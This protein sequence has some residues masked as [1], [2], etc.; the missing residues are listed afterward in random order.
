[1][2]RVLSEDG[3]SIYKVVSLQW[4]RWLGHVLHIPDHQLPQRVTFSGVEVGLKKAR[5]GQGETWHQS[6]DSLTSELSQA[7]RCRLSGWDRCDYRNQLLETLNEMARIRLEWHR[8]IHSSSSSNSELP[9]S[10]KSFLFQQFVF[11]RI[12]SLMYNLIYCL[13]L[14]LIIP[15]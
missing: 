2:N 10:L 9:N 4:L 7:N 6:M 15:F 13:I 14:L 8:Y 3:K 5:D 11:S 12:A 1:M